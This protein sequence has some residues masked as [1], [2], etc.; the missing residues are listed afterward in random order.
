M[1]EPRWVRVCAE[2]VL[3]VHRGR[4]VI[5]CTE[6]TFPDG[7]EY[8]LQLSAAERSRLQEE[9]GGGAVGCGCFLGEDQ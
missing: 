2:R 6:H 8:I 9:L 4:S 5:L 3:Y 7:A 1:P